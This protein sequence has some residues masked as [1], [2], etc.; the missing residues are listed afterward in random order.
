MKK[1]ATAMLMALSLVSLSAAA[2]PMQMSDT[3]MARIVAGKQ[4]MTLW[5][6][7]IYY[8]LRPTRQGA[9][10]LTEFPT[11]GTWTDTGTTCTSGRNCS[12]LWQSNPGWIEYSGI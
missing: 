11:A 4:A 12:S 8:M 1:T 5:T 3:E 10:S 6:D 2:E 7:G 9:P